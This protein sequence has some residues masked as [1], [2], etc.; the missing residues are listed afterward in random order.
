MQP[1]LRL[2]E[3]VAALSL[4]TDLG[5]G[6][7]MEQAL[8]TCLIAVGL[9]R[10]LGLDAG[11]LSDVYY[12]SLLRFLGCTSDA[13]ET[14]AIVGGDELAFRA[15][16]APALGG[17]PIDIMRHAWPAVTAGQ[18]LLG[19]LGATAKFLSQGRQI[20]GGVAAH[21]EVAENLASRLD[22]P[23][24]IRLGLMHSL[25]RWDGKGLPG[26]ISGEAISLPARI[27][28]LARDAEILGRSREP[29][30]LPA[31]LH[32][33]A[34]SA[35]DPSLVRTFDQHHVEILSEAD[36]PSAWEAVL[37]AEPNPRREV[38]PEEL[39]S[40]LE[41]FADF[42]DLKAPFLLGHSR[43]VAELAAR[44]APDPE[45]ETVYRAGLV[46][47]LGR[48]AVPSGVWAK[49]GP[50]TDGDW[51]KVRLH[52]YYGERILSRCP[53]LTELVPLAGMHHE[54]LDGS[55]YHRNSRS[56]EIPSGARLL[57]AADAYQAMTQ[58]RPYRPARQPDEA[59]RELE[60]D[61]AAGRL[62]GASV[63]AVLAAAGQP[64]RAARVKWPAGLSDREVEVLRLICRGHSKKQV[65]AQLVIS[66]STADHHVRH[67]YEKIGVSTRAGA[68]VFALQQRLL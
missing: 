52:S 29:G 1:N 65:A 20:P 15:A 22:M 16:I 35:Y 54:R 49:P 67:I 14:A 39:S 21:C 64:R 25:E 48:V 60:R 5:M 53:G 2:A 19:R 42:A 61:V 13:Y 18:G 32:H 44:A 11:E 43:G 9:G 56:E 51:E 23:A 59:V 30:E 40:Y 7:P 38:G 27:A 4:I 12:V 62:D 47:D 68:A 33:R 36:S 46:H 58:P 41:V 57:A 24:S 45:S 55:G 66:S 31:I 28:F 10:R 34:G 3:L 6:Q 63:Q 8:R 26:R 50:L 37:A 17:T